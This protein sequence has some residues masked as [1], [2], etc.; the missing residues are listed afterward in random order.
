MQP[1]T[2]DTDLRIA[3]E[4]AISNGTPIEARALLRQLWHQRPGPALAGFVVA[5]FEQLRNAL[6]P[7]RARVALLRW[8]TFEPVIPLLRASAW[9]SNIELDVQIGDFNTYAQEILDPQSQ[10]YRFEPD[11]VLLAIQT[12]DIIPELYDRFADLTADDINSI[13]ERVSN[14]F[15]TWI[16]TFRSR[17]QAHMIIHNLELPLVAAN[18][19]LDMQSDLGQFETIQKINLALRKIAREHTGIYVLDY[20]ALIARHGREIWHDQRKWLTMRVPLRLSG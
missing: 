14:D 18:G 11:I 7:A 6:A 20:D 3:I 15:Y 17:S 19:I 16:Q 2:N 10:L 9:A 12:Q 13:V 4:Q 5:R 8:C 1:G